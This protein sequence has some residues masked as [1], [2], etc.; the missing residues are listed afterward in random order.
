[1][2]DSAEV[3]VMSTYWVEIDRVTGLD[4]GLHIDMIM[5]VWE[6]GKGDVQKTVRGFSARCVSYHAVGT[7]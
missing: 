4:L 5:L 1:M 6:Y 7:K 3:S 2:S